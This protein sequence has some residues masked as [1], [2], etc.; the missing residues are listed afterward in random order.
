[1]QFIKFVVAGGTGAVVNILSRYLL[2]ISLSYSAAIIIAYFFGMI[3]TYVLSRLFVFQESG[4]TVSRQF[5]RF[6]LVNMAAILIV[7]GVSVGFSRVL[8]PAIGMIF[9]ADDVAHILGVGSTAVTSYVMHK[10]F[11]FRS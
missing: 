3:S 4:S 1:M 9:Y 10:N 7:W 5:A 6:T 8:F 2:D 11:T